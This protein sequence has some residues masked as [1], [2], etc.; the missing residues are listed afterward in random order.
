MYS[1]IPR[2]S[3][4]TFPVIKEILS[5]GW[6]EIPNEFQGSG[7]PGNTLEYLINIEVNNNDYPDLNDWELKFHGGGS[8]LLTLF[9]KDPEPKGVLNEIVDKFGWENKHGNISFR[10]TIKGKSE[11]GFRIVNENNRIY[12]K[13]DI[14][15]NIMLYWDHNILL[16]QLAAK[17]RRLIIVHGRVNK[18]ERKVIYDRAKAYWDVD[19]IGFCN[20]IENGLIYADFDARTTMMR[21][22]ALRNHGTKFRIRI[23][24]IDYLYQNSQEI[25]SN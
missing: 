5:L 22:T 23:S 8:N 3:S 15:K 12:I 1:E 20:A 17:L 24:D 21:G 7:A 9:H 6:M 14:D 16:G 18:R 25:L 11:R 10:H 13:N 19:L 4:N 2:S